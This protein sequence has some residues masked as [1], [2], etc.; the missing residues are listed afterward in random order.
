MVAK[1]PIFEEISVPYFYLSGE[2][3]AHFWALFGAIFKEVFRK[4]GSFARHFVI[5]GFKQ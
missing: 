4:K 2:G 3:K 1:A 5:S